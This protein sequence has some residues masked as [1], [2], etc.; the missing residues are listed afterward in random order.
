M[1]FHFLPLILAASI[2]AATAFAEQ[3]VSIQ[4]TSLNL[5]TE[6][7]AIRCSLKP[8]AALTAVA[9]A[10][11]D[12]I[13]VKV[14]NAP[15]CPSEGFVHS[16]FVKSKT[17]PGLQVNAE[18]LSFRSEPNLSEDSYECA[19]PRGTKLVQKAD[20]PV[21]KGDNT[22]V[23][24]RLGDAVN[25]CPEEGWVSKDFLKASAEAGSGLVA[26]PVIS[27]N[28][29]T[30][31]DNVPD[32]NGAGCNDRNRNPTITTMNRVSDGIGNR[33]SD[34]PPRPPAEVPNAG[35]TFLKSLRTLIANPRARG[36]GLKTNRGLVQMPLFS[37]RGN[38]GACGSHHYN[39]NS[40]VGSDAY[41]NPLTACVL[42]DLMQEWKRTVCPTRSGCTLQ[43][44][45]ISHITDP[46]FQ[47]AHRTHTVGLC[48]DI[49]P[50]RK[51]G[52]ADSPIVYTDSSYD[53]VAM[54]KL[55]DMAKARGANLGQ[56]FF[57][58]TRIG[59]RPMTG[60]SNHLHVC[61]PDNAKTRAVCKNLK[62]DPN[63]CPELP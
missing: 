42:T 62:V 22:F 2:P 63:V 38:V 16:G 20:R 15:G 31:P 6:T 10:D 48:V 41:T 27:R 28:T 23:K 34:E 17:I 56:L 8:T 54:K 43:W 5:R 32:C 44:G 58:D 18:G 33:I 24:V 40:P 11:G 39:P 4:A 35:G 51:G 7:G 55:V 3:A 26:L 14:Q 25:G 1:K 45:D 29:G 19:L 47:G 57:N 50:M 30:P 21:K 61:F 53:R 37:P 36:T 13:K 59:T 46:G 60:H 12:W 52:F 49:R 9:R